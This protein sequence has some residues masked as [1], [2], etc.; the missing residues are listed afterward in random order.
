MP[1]VIM[2]SVQTERVGFAP[3]LRCYL[4]R[5]RIQ[6]II[7]DNVPLDPRRKV[8]SHGEACVAMI[9]GILFQVLQLY[10]LCHTPPCPILFS[11]NDLVH[12]MLPDTGRLLFSLLF[13]LMSLL[14]QCCCYLSRLFA[15]S[16]E[17]FVQFS[18]LPDLL[19][20][21]RCFLHDRVRI[22]QSF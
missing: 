6:Q 15:L 1:D 17:L 2:K 4:D 21:P 3:I 22:S 14:R 10:R 7:D 13:L 9:T 8:L 19:Q 12:R 16:F 11:L 20:Y 18:S 5:C